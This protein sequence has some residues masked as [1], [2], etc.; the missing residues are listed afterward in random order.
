MGGRPRLNRRARIQ[1]GRV[2]FGVFSTS[3]FVPPAL[4]SDYRRVTTDLGTRISK[5]VTDLGAGISKKVTDAGSQLTSG[6]E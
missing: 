4:S 5:N 1:L 6:Q 3:R 2:H